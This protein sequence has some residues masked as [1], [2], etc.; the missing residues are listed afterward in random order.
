VFILEFQY[1]C[2]MSQYFETSLKQCVW[3]FLCLMKKTLH[4][5]LKGQ[6]VCFVDI[7]CF[8]SCRQLFKE[9]IVKEESFIFPSIFSEYDN[10]ESLWVAACSKLYEKNCTPSSIFKKYE[11]I[12]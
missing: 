4:I 12:V 2:I 5:I 7:L 1:H 10:I 11:Y 8:A 9:E 6:S 3:F